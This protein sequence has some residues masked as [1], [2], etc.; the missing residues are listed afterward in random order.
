MSDEP[1]PQSTVPPNLPDE[2]Q[3]QAPVPPPE[4]AIKPDETQLQPPVAPPPPEPPKDG[5]TVVAGQLYLDCIDA[6]TKAPVRLSLP[7]KFPVLARDLAT[8]LAK[9]PE[10]RDQPATLLTYVPM[11]TPDGKQTLVEQR[12]VAGTFADIIQWVK[13]RTLNKEEAAHQLMQAL[14][15]IA[16]HSCWKVVTVTLLDE[17]ENKEGVRQPVSGGFSLKFVPDEELTVGE[18]RQHYAATVG[19]AEDFRENVEA[20]RKVS[21]LPSRIVKPGDAGFTLPRRPR[22]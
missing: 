18:L 7:S 15:Q 6:Q 2:T 17:A 13:S 14:A 12:V 20:A 4:M 10:M 22:R 1:Q 8:T 5:A 16:N 11:R 3:P 19:H 9:W 21:L